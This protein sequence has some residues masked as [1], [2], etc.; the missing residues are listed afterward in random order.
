MIHESK[1]VKASYTRYRA[2]GPEL[3]Q[4]QMT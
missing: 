1:K 4:V 2:F 3:I